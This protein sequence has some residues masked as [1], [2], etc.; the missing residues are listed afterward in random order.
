[1][2]AKDLR[3]QHGLQ[4]VTSS[5]EQKAEA[6]AIKAK[7]DEDSSRLPRAAS[8]ASE[9]S[10]EEAVAS[11]KKRPIRQSV[12]YE[13]AVSAASYVKSHTKGFLSLGSEPQRDGDGDAS[14][15]TAGQPQADGENSPRLYNSEMAACM[16]ASTMT[17]VVAAG[18]R[19]KQEAARN[20]QSLQSSPCEWFVCD[21]FHT[22]TRCFVIQ[23]IPALAI[24]YIILYGPMI[25]TCISETCLGK[26][27]EKEKLFLCE[28]QGSDSLASWQA[29]LFFEPTKFEVTF[30]STHCTHGPYSSTESMNTCYGCRVPMCLCIEEFMKLQREYMSNLCQK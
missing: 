7:L 24:Q 27:Y 20:L 28:L 6:A 2:Q 29:N 23:V 15:K 5:L 14:W 17:A 11:E 8:A 9:S 3:K 21:D 13:I 12:A 30:S 18:E 26:G 10:S 22:Y 1:M 19:E 16:A 25:S 4:F